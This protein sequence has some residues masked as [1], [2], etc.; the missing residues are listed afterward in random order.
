MTTGAPLNYDTKQPPG[1][2]AQRLAAFGSG[3]TGGAN[4]AFADGSI[5]F[6]T[7]SID[8]T[9]YQSLSTRSGGEVLN[10]SAF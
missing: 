2:T 7:S 6:I 3:H 1:S 10:S 8:T 9:T 5:H 4:F